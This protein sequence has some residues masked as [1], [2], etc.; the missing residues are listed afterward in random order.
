MTTTVSTILLIGSD[1]GT[2]SRLERLVKEHLGDC[3]LAVHEETGP[4]LRFA[5]RCRVEGIVVDGTDDAIGSCRELKASEVTEAIPVMWLSKNSGSL[6]GEASALGVED[7][8]P[9][10]VGDQELVSR[11]RLIQLLH[12][13]RVGEKRLRRRLKEMETAQRKALSTVERRYRR[14]VEIWPDT[15]MV[16]TDGKVTFVNEAGKKLL[17]A[18]EAD[19]V[20][21]QP[22]TAL[23][24][25]ASKHVVLQLVE[26]C[27]H[28]SESTPYAL[29]K[30]KRP[31]GRGI[32]A[33][34][35]AVS[36]E[37]T[38]GQH[39]LLL[40]RDVGERE[41]LSRKFQKAQRMEAVGQLA[42]GVAHDFNNILTTIRG[43]SDLVLSSLP[44]GDPLAGELQEINNATERAASLTRQL[45]AFSRRQVMEPSSVDLNKV[46]IDIKRM[47]MRVIGE[48]IELVTDLDPDLGVIRADR[49]QI[50]QVIMNLAINARDAIQGSGQV[51]LTTRNVPF[52]DRAEMNGLDLPSGP[53][54]LFQMTDTGVGMT[55]ETALRI[56]EPFFTTK[57]LDKGTGLGLSTVYGIV[58][59]SGG[60]VAVESEVGKGTTFRIYLPIRPELNAALAPVRT[61]QGPERGWETVLLVEDESTVRY[62]AKRLLE[63]AG[64]SVIPAAHGAEALA[65]CEQHEGPI[66]LIVTDIVMPEM[67]GLELVERLRESYP[68]LRVILMSGYSEEDELDLAEVPVAFLQK[69]F[70]YKELTA[71]VRRMLDNNVRK[72]KQS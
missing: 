10:S 25:S 57:G 19:A 64:Y 15:M 33:E 51:T 67:G 20:L 48:Q 40:I 56:F 17:G 6:A 49:S 55:E 68:D 28:S 42:G 39:V 18:K 52:E 36:F 31:G 27:G 8:V 66:H 60:D 24:S 1:P 61:E 45:L 12:R 59:Q 30:L 2:R 41:N 35:A 71:E 22:V 21:G 7:F 26:S 70:S 50:E 23:V 11:L 29:M 72:G 34:V 13:S 63:R 47:L 14:L 54:V 16:C 38:D 9:W 44:E 53:A 65:L 32:Q 46:V 3:E 69:P 5:A 37:R 58:K 43:Y 62:L 4:A